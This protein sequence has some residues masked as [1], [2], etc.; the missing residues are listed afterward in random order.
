MNGR[1]NRTNDYAFK[2]IMGSEEG[3]EALIS[4]LNAVLKPEPGKELTSVQLL[5]R[6]LDPRYL[7]DRAARLDILAQTAK[8]TL[9]N[10]EVQVINQHNIDKR[11]LFYWAGL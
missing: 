10:I 6:E 4:F 8:G 3:Q 11:T 5:D 2:R 9:I 1:I 7:L